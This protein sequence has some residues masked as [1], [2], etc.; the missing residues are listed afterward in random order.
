MNDFHGKFLEWQNSDDGSLETYMGSSL[1]FREF[2]LADKAGQGS[3]IPHELE[4]FRRADQKCSSGNHGSLER[5]T[6]P[7]GEVLDGGQFTTCLNNVYNHL[8]TTTPFLQNLREKIF[9]SH[10]VD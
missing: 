9:Y 3:I 2:L 1:V 4:H 7:N 5:I 10:N 6:L 8:L